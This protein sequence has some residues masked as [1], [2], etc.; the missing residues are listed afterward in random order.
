METFSLIE[1]SKI[2]SITKFKLRYHIDFGNVAMPKKER[3]HF[4]FTEQDIYN[5]AE[6]L[7]I[8]KENVNFDV[9]NV[10]V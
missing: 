3:G 5:I 9:L 8:P 10:N 6:K 4:R 1:V 7:K 2:I